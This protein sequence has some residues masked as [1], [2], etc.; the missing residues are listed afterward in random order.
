[1]TT[2]SG[3]AIITYPRARRRSKAKEKMANPAVMA[4]PERNTLAYS[5]VPT[6]RWRGSCARLSA[7][8]AIQAI[9]MRNVNK[10]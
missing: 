2:A 5:S 9:G 1:M 6:N 4:S 8:Q 3:I 10:R 7:K